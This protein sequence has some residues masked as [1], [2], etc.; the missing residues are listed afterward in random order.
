MYGH[1][2][3]STRWHEHVERIKRTASIAQEL[4]DRH[5]LE[6]A[7]DLSC[8]DSSLLNQLTVMSKQGRD[9][10]IDA[11]LDIIT[12]VDLFLCTETIEHLPAP[13]TTLE[14]IAEKTRWLVLSTPLDEDPAMGNPEHYWSFTA[15]D[16]ES[17]LYQ[18]G[19]TDWCLYML[20]EPNWAYTYQV[21]TAR[22]TVA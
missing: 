15:E 10:N 22:S 8:G 18:S 14:R 9:G 3:D 6:T 20:A 1:R 16:V 7:A 12:C 11:D 2:Y 21:W 17:I 13:W 19:F 4:I 5:S